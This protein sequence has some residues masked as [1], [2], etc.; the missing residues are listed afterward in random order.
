VSADAM[1]DESV[2]TSLLFS[3]PRRNKHRQGSFALR[4]EAT[5]TK[6][7]NQHIDTKETSNQVFF[8]KNSLTL[9]ITPL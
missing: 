4:L 1:L 2:S 5:P 3:F 8:N 7:Q 9:S 6:V